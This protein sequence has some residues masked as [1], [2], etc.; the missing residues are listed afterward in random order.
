MCDFLTLICVKVSETL[1]ARDTPETLPSYSVNATYVLDSPSPFAQS[2]RAVQILGVLRGERVGF[3]F[4]AGLDKGAI[5]WDNLIRSGGA[6]VE[7]AVSI[8]VIATRKHLPYPRGTVP[9]N[10][11]G[12]FDPS[13]IKG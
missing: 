9:K 12:M 4:D 10:N 2:S 7:V 3:Y 11:L 6:G 13:H 1:R 8:K 5:Q